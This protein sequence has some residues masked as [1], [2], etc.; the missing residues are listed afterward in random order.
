MTLDEIKAIVS[1]AKEQRLVWVKVDGLEFKFQEEALL[2]ELP[3]EDIDEMSPEEIART[4]QEK[5]GHRQA[6]HLKELF[7]V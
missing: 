7:N 4:F 5:A 1:Y 2:P 3:R 6:K